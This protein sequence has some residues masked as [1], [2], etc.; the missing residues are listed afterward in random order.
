MVEGGRGRGTH[1]GKHH[2]GDGK[3]G[4]QDSGNTQ[5]MLI[6]TFRQSAH[7]TTV[8]VCVCDVCVRVDV[9]VCVCYALV[10]ARVPVPV[11]VC[12]IFV[13]S[14]PKIVLKLFFF[15]PKGTGGILMPLASC[16][17]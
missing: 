8:V 17:P 5:V 4:A 12:G 16:W 3:D 2:T 11:S 6:V 9:R 15:F 1:G 13:L 14:H 7:H 10:H